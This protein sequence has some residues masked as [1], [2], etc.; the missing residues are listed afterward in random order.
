[1]FGS[2]T[3][4]HFDHSPSISEEAIWGDAEWTDFSTSFP[5]T[6]NGKHRDLK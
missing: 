3:Q 6:H 4:D 2:L 5:V 1:M